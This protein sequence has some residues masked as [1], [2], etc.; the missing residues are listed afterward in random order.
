MYLWHRL[1]DLAGLLWP[2]LIRLSKNSR[3]SKGKGQLITEHSSFPLEFQLA[4]G[5]YALQTAQSC[6]QL[7]I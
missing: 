1:N 3:T 6:Y 2:F 4:D 5:K 7:K